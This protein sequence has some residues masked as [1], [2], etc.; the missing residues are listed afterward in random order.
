MFCTNCGAEIQD[1]I[2]FCPKCGSP[3]LKANN[4]NSFT[5]ENEQLN[6]SRSVKVENEKE[7]MLKKLFSTE[8]RVNRLS[9][10]LRSVSLFLIL[11][12]PLT[13]L[14]T[15]LNIEQNYTQIF[16]GLIINIF[17]WPLQMRR[18]Q[19]IGYNGKFILTWN[20][21]NCIVGFSAPYIN[22]IFILFII[23]LVLD[24]LKMLLLLIWP[25]RKCENIYGAPPFR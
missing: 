17:S 10:F 7:S 12:I 22:G 16:T 8:G 11:A 25:G 6:F 14:G 23:M 19:D 21:I 15:I 9:Y 24:S 20:I 1:D 4:T 3:I 2:N 18:F 13:I 5:K